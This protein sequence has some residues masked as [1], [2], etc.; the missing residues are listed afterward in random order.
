MDKSEVSLTSEE[1]NGLKRLVAAAARTASTTWRPARCSPWNGPRASPWCIS[2]GC[3]GRLRRQTGPCGPAR[4][5]RLLEYVD[6]DHCGR[7]IP[8]EDR[9]RIYA[10]IDA[11]RDG[12]RPPMSEDTADADYRTMPE[13]VESGKRLMLAAPEPDMPGFR[14]ARR[15]P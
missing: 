14:G 11:L 10:W 3:C 1:R 15:E 12:R 7:Q 5:S 9:R 13:A 4:A 8:L 6:G 2:T